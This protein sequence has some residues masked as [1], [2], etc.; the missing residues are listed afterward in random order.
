MIT[1]VARTLALPVM[2]VL[3][4]CSEPN[5]DVDVVETTAQVEPRQVAEFL[6][7]SQAQYRAERI[8]NVHYQLQLSLPAQNKPFNGTAKITFELA[9]AS[10]PITLDFVEGTVTSLS[11]NGAAVAV[12]HNGYFITLPSAVLSEG[13]QTVVVEYTHPYRRDGRG[14][15]WFED[16]VDGESYVYSQFESWDFNKVFPGFDQPDLKA[17]YT[18]TVEAPSHWQVI[19]ATRETSVTDVSSQRKQWQFAPSETFSTYLISLHAGPY[20]MWEE[21]EPFRIPLRLFARKSYSEHVEVQEWFT[22]T[23]QGFDYF[24]S[25]FG[26]DYPFTKYDQVLV[27]EF[28]FGA[29]ENVGAVTFAER[30][31]PRRE[32]TK[33]DRETMAIVVMHEMAHH[34]FGDLVTMQW[35]DDLWLNESFADLMGNQATAEATEYTGA[36][37][38]FSTRRKSWG[39]SEDQWITT[40]PIVQDIYNTDVVMSSF[41]GITYA[42][43]ASSL[44]QLQHLLGKDSFQ[45]GIAQ[46]FKTYAWQNTQLTDFIG[47]LGDV[48]ERDLSAWTQS[49]LMQSGV[50]ALKAQ[51]ICENDVIAEFDLIQQPANVS[52]AVREH[53][54]DVL[55]VDSSGE[56]TTFDAHLTA[57][58]NPQADAI[59][60]P[61]PAFVLPNVSDYT[62]ATILLDETSIA[63]LQ[64]HLP[65][66]NN[67]VERGMI[68]RSLKESVYA[69]ELTAPAYL[70]MALKH[71][72][73]EANDGVLSTQL[74]VV[75][76]VY[77]FLVL[78]Q[79]QVPEAKAAATEYRAKLEAMAWQ[80]Y[81]QATDDSLKHSWLGFWMDTLH[82]SEQLANARALL[83]AAELSIDDQW[84]LAG[85][86]V[87]EGAAE[88]TVWVEKLTEQDNS[89]N[90]QLNEWV[91]LAQAADSEAKRQWLQEVANVESDKSYT[92]MRSILAML[93]AVEQFAL[94][95]S[96]KTDILAPLEN[97][98]S[99]LSPV[100]LATYAQSVLPVE[101]SKKAEADKLALAAKPDMPAP[102][103][104]SLKK[105]SQ[106]EDICMKVAGALS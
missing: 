77:G 87:R 43:G 29:M 48:A 80:Q 13:E 32:Q 25:Y 38:L 47:T 68:W 49:W 31:Q 105:A 69:G 55:L 24:E 19:S 58:H 3:T 52:G 2:V 86:L 67:P 103:V 79:Q 21:A 65:E 53:S 89:A 12:D 71:L 22:V 95:T 56:R 75:S 17:T 81:Q 54:L 18:L 20:K 27:P 82:S 102:A 23:R 30:L 83:E 97:I 11:V 59:G 78:A 98:N 101:C 84:S 37:E 96:L 60:K 70:D 16:P 34:W 72:A 45:Q 90:A 9:D 99:A 15:H 100:L 7:R 74:N 5:T 104:K 8:S 88:G 41:D 51:F 1:R 92:Q 61:C 39:Y 57:E 6:S 26:T 76:S 35:W 44:I 91:A 62:F 93:F 42:K 50:N 73:G 106:V 4:A 66:F 33:A 14:L 63:Y 85:A 28:V 64:D 94:Q 40:H 36:M 46:Y 10:S